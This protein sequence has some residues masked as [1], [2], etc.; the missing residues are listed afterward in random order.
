MGKQRES[1][2]GLSFH[3]KQFRDGKVNGTYQNR[4]ECE[5]EAQIYLLDNAA[6]LDLTIPE[7]AQTKK[8]L[9]VYRKELLKWKEENHDYL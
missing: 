9:D 4:L 5:I 1:F 2:K 3:A 8:A 6:V 7:I